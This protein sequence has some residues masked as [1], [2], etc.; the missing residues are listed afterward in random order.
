MNP[1]RE[2]ALVQ[3][4]HLKML[5][6]FVSS[7]FLIQRLRNPYGVFHIFSFKL[8]NTPF[9]LRFFFF[10]RFIYL[11]V[12]TSPLGLLV[13]VQPATFPGGGWEKGHRGD[14]CNKLQSAKMKIN[15]SLTQPSVRSGLECRQASH[16]ETTNTLFKFL[17]AT[18]RSSVLT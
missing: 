13:A 17:P 15:D 3:Y 8:F 14:Q 2:I 6:I 18:I 7:I 4:G 9:G 1:P 10:P 11:F 5:W 12:I 16:R